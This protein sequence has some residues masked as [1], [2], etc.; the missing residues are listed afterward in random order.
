MTVLLFLLYED[1][2]AL[3]EMHLLP[4]MTE[5][6]PLGFSSGR[7]KSE[8]K[9]RRQGGVCGKMKINPPNAWGKA[10]LLG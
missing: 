1:V 9:D 7:K 3:K 2:S 5:N 4:L 6:L 8:K 10:C